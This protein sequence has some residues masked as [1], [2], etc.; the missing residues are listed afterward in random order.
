LIE[1]HKT[2]LQR[3][4]LAPHERRGQL[5]RIGCPQRMK[6]QDTPGLLTHRRRGFDLCQS[7]LERP[8]YQ[9]GLLLLSFAQD[10][11]SP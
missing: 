3:I 8:K 6:A 4:T 1:A 7:P 11:F 9:T 5:Q 2:M 10:C